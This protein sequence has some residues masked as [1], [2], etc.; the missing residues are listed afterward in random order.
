MGVTV[1]MSQVEQ[2][3]FGELDELVGSA[4]WLGRL[5]NSIATFLDTTRFRDD[6]GLIEFLN[7]APVNMVMELLPATTLLLDEVC[8]RVEEIQR[9]SDAAMDSA[10]ARLADAEKLTDAG[11]EFGKIIAVEFDKDRKKNGG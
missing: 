11:D 10:A 9:A 5:H 4:L 2:F 7:H 1:D 8:S 6:I 3:T